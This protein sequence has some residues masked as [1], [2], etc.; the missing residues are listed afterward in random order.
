MENLKYCVDF[1][2]N[3]GEKGAKSVKFTVFIRVPT[4]IFVPKT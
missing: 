2:L 4:F 3:Q 1:I